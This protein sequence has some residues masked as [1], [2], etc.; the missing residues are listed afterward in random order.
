MGNLHCSSR[1][2]KKP[3]R[4]PDKT[5][6]KPQKIPEII[7]KHLN[8]HA[9]KEK[10]PKKT[11]ID[12]FELEESLKFLQNYDNF[13]QFLEINHTITSPKVF[14]PIESS[15][16]SFRKNLDFSIKN[17]GK[18]LETPLKHEIF[19]KT[20]E[21]SLKN[22]EFPRKSFKELFQNDESL[23]L[24]IKKPS[25]NTESLKKSFISTPYFE[26]N[27]ELLD[28]LPKNPLFSSGFSDEKPREFAIQQTK[29]D[30]LHFSSGFSNSVKTRK[31]FSIE[32]SSEEES[33]EPQH[34]YIN[35]FDLLQNELKT[36]RNSLSPIE[37]PQIPVEKHEKFK[38]N[39][40]Q[41]SFKTLKKTDFLSPL[42]KN[43][44][45]ILKETLN[46]SMKK[47]VF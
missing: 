12:L 1:N 25:K 35:L 11:S 23:Y 43:P 36:R 47:P 15:K 40:S 5:L 39:D 17:L 27:N 14:F 2:T 6:I 4:N 21:I 45:K 22:D 29:L 16:K 3:L 13:L 42:P 18:N 19:R 28:Y 32:S 7:K 33:E 44:Q 31:E 10:S 30:S 38:K 9:F 8:S 37:I 46:L 20:L 41:T 24:P 34:I 26:K